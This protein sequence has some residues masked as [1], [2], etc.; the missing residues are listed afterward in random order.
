MKLYNELDKLNNE[1]KEL[2][3][4]NDNAID[5]LQELINRI[6]EQIESILNK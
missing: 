4:Q 5:T 2:K 6:N 3:E 1:I